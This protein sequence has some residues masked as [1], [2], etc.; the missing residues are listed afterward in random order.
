MKVGHGAQK[1]L[2]IFY[3]GSREVFPS[4]IAHDPPAVA[5]RTQQSQRQRRGADPCFKHAGTRVHVGPHEDHGDILG[6]EDLRASRHLQRV[7]RQGGHQGH[8]GLPP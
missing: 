7:F 2:D 8:H 3:R 1:S 6:V 5:D 4:F